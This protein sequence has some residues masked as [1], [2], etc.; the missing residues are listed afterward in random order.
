M[1]RSCNN[2][3]RSPASNHPKNHG[4]PSWARMLRRISFAFRAILLLL[5]FEFACAGRR[6]SRNDNCSPGSHPHSDR[7]NWRPA[8]IFSEYIA[9][10]NAGLE[11]YSDRR[12]AKLFGVSRARWQRIQ[13]AATLPDELFE[14][15]LEQL[16]HMPSM[17]EFASVA[18]ALQGRGPAHDVE[19]CPHCGGTLRIRSRW[20]PSTARIVKSGWTSRQRTRAR[21]ANHALDS[22]VVDAQGRRRPAALQTLLDAE[23]DEAKRKAIACEIRV[24]KDA[25]MPIGTP[26]ACPDAER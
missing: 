6:M 24:A 10:C 1:Q 16:P 2:I 19:R 8:E 14:R 20:R 3:G 17:R 7:P 4:A 15:L 12:A 11:R 26:A 21:Q 18:L 23:R 25:L 22:R 13:L 9:S 5:P